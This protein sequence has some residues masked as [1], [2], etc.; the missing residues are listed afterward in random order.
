[1]LADV[2]M[3]YFARIL[4][5]C[6]ITYWQTGRWLGPIACPNCRQTVSL[7]IWVFT[8]MRFSCIFVLLKLSIL[9]GI[10]FAFRS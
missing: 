3:K 4:G 10:L 1:M 5:S 6:I 2:V 8:G 7:W 9:C